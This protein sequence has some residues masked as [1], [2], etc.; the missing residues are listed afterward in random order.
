[1][2]VVHRVT[3]LSLGAAFALTLQLGADEKQG[4]LSGTVL[5]MDKS[6][7]EIMLQGDAHRV[8]IY[9]GATKFTR[10]SPSNTSTNVP[11]SADQV[12][13]GNYLTCVGQ[14]DNVKLAATM[15]TVRSSKHP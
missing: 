6:K 14:W 7:S 12:K 1:M 11:S 13:E 3:A 8:V 5:S 9:S 2:R 10:G 15:C 4:R